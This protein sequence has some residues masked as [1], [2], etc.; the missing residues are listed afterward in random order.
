MILY[1]IQPKFKLEELERTGILKSGDKIMD[2]YFLNSYAWLEDKM[3]E[4]LP[5]PTIECK[6]PIWA[7]Y[8]RHNKRKPDLRNSGYGNKGEELYLIKFEIED[9]KVL[10]TDFDD[11]HIVLNSNE[12]DT[13]LK[14]YSLPLDWF[15]EEE[16]KDS[17][18]KGWQI[19]NDKLIYHFDN[20]IIDTN[21]KKEF[22]QATMWYVKIEQVKEIIK[23]KCR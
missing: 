7:W 2:D 6:H 10:L 21:S 12:Q 11:W 9:D 17:I 1:T 23:F 5:A 3:R 14:Y 20:I 15:S 8:K 13:L 4:L 16:T 19:Q 18:E 22:I